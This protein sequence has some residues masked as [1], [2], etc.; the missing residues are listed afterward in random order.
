MLQVRS[1][2]REALALQARAAFAEEGTRVP[3][4]AEVVADF[5]RWLTDDAEMSEP[6]SVAD[7]ER[8]QLFELLGV[9]GRGRD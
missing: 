8:E 4:V 6:L 7:I 9:G 2:E 5:D 1:L 3:S